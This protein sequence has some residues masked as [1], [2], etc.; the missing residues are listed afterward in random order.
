MLLVA[1]QLQDST[2]L[3]EINSEE[4]GI[5]KLRSQLK[6][7]PSSYSALRYQPPSKTQAPSFLSIPPLNRQTVLVS[8]F[9][10]NS[11]YIL[12]FREPPCKLDSF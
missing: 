8:P 7:L 1:N 6:L 9:L 4:I 11:P 5:S 10:G 3:L 2:F 12:V